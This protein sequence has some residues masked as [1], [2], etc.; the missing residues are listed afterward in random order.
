MTVGD[1]T[2]FKDSFGRVRVA[3]YLVN[4][5][6]QPVG[7]VEAMVELKDSGG[8]TLQQEHSIYTRNIVPPGQRSP[9]LAVFLGP[10]PDWVRADVQVQAQPE[11]LTPE[12]SAILNSVQTE[13]VKPSEN[14]Q[15]FAV[16]GQVKNGWSTP[17]T[18]VSVLGILYDATGKPL[19]V[20]EGPSMFEQ[21][22]PGKTLSFS[23]EFYNSQSR[24]ADQLKY[25]L[26]VDA[27]PA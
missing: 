20:R 27:S 22:Q 21:L 8:R 24:P 13:D 19:D 6:Q 1:Y 11:Q 16:A 25:D 7:H 4:N 5:G 9:F 26:Y 14:G 17:V 15:G 18:D 12:Q 10:P 3:G 23:F 2:A